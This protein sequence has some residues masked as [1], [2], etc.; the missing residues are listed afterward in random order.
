ML[1]Q[2]WDGGVQEDQKKWDFAVLILE[3]DALSMV[4]WIKTFTTKKKPS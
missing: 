2:F 4:K 1:F 3:S